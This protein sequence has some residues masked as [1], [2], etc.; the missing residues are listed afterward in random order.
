MPA[1][2]SWAGST[3]I[4]LKLKPFEQR[5]TRIELCNITALEQSQDRGHPPQRLLPVLG[6]QPDKPPFVESRHGG[7]AGPR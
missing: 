7:L 6:R 5:T 4:R 3:G 1:S 2:G